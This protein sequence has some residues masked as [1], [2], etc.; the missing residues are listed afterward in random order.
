MSFH[1]AA[2]SLS[3]AQ[4]TIS[5]QIQ[6]LEEELG[7]KLFDRLGKRIQLTE[8]GQ[9]LLPHARRMLN[10]AKEAQAEVTS[11]TEPYGS[12]NIMI[13]ESLL[14]HR[15]PA[16]LSSFRSVHPGLSLN[17]QT[18]TFHGLEQDL[19]KGIADLA[20]LLADTASGSNM[21]VE[22]LGS[23]RLVLAAAPDHPLAAK[24]QV[25][26]GDLAGRRLILSTSDCSY[27]RSFE[28]LLLEGKIY[29]GSIMEFNSVAA[30]K[31]AVAAGLGLTILP[32]MAV[33]E[34]AGQGLLSVLDWA[35][36]EMETAI[37]MI[38]HK[39]KWLSPA[40]RSFMETDREGLAG[41]C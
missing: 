5:A 40:L 14:T 35:G 32:W 4:S 26:A 27:R 31:K 2:Q 9:K 21:V 30:I 25:R 33:E 38:R 20:F 22:F 7:V 28:E 36:E 6:A 39:D 37:L 24:K 16:L 23:V 41:D 3:Y 12:L 34:E 13:P 15:L 19:R 17:F 11:K 18:C 10:L 29:L 1:K 8:A